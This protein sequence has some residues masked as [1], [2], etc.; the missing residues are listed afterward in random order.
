MGTFK[1]CT[2]YVV[3]IIY[4]NFG[5]FITKWTIDMF[6]LHQLTALYIVIL[7]FNMSWNIIYSW[8]MTKYVKQL[9]AILDF[10][11]AILKLNQY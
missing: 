4:T 6:F 11:G 10:Q 8:V 7:F 9:A 1:P 5:A 2:L 3:T